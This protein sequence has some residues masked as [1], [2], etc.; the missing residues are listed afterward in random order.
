MSAEKRIRSDEA[1]KEERTERKLAHLAKIAKNQIAEDALQVQRDH[2]AVFKRYVAH[3][4]KV[5][6]YDLQRSEGSE[7]P[8]DAAGNGDG[9][10]NDGRKDSDN[11]DVKD[12]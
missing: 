1:E 10:E 3:F 11:D 5:H 12:E 4:E 2:V 9:E 7:E 8:K 6:A